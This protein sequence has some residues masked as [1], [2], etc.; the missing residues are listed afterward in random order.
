[1][2]LSVQRSPVHVDELLPAFSQPDSLFIFLQTLSNQ[3]Q[4]LLNLSIPGIEALLI[5]VLIE[6]CQRN[7]IDSGTLFYIYLNCGKNDNSMAVVTFIVVQPSIFLY[8]NK[9]PACQGCGQALLVSSSQSVTLRGFGESTRTCILCSWRPTSAAW[10]FTVML[11][12]VKL[13]VS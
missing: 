12:G 4:R 2:V 6:K 13:S 5:W 1:M 3:G 8:G 11:T 7:R 10:T 9:L